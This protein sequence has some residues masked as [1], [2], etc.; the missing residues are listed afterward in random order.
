[1]RKASNNATYVF[2]LLFI[3]NLLNY[4]DRYVLMGAAAVIAKELGFG[5]DGIGYLSS[6]FIVL[7]ALSV[8]PLGIWADH[9][10]RKN[11]IAICVAIWSITTALTALAGNFLQLLLSRVLLGI[12]EAGYA[13]ASSAILADYF[14]RV[15]RA[16]TLSWWATAT[17]GGLMIGMI[18]GGVVAGL[19][20]GT[21]RWAFLCTGIPGLI[22]AFLVWHIREPAHNEADEQAALEDPDS[23]SV[24][25]ASERLV[26]P[27]KIIGRVRILLRIKSLLIL[28]A[29]QIFSFF[30]LVASAVYLPTWLQQKDLFGLSSGAAG[31]YTGVGIAV[32]GIAGIIS[33]GYLANVLN[34]RYPGACVMICGLGFSIS[35]PFYLL[36]IVTA[37]NTRNLLL[38]TIL[39]FLTVI[40]VSMYAG[41]SIAALQDVVPS[42]IRASAVA[43][44]ISIAHL[45]GDAALPSL[46]GILARA[47]DP[48]HGDH[49]IQQL[50]GHD[51]SMALIY[52]C[53]AALLIAGIIGIIG[54][55]WVKADMATA[56]LA[57]QVR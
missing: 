49:F 48:T 54:A 7:F 18:A 14:S 32:A 27:E 3:I 2:A 53:P 9:A 57:E 6:A 22:M 28:T 44:S 1:M 17:T 12:G 24:E 5:I 46:V 30:V 25:G 40:L 20:F 11:V 55:R 35:A 42:A 50:A 15:K 41:P 26:L 19:G 38:Y 45:L 13:P 56:Q 51:L 4:L 10:K 37:M 52:T 33:G 21:W 29:M 31:L 8:I 39:F 43:I 47:I 36:S 34:C 16:K 23:Y